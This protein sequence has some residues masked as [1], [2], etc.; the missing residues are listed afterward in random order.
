M[1]KK[2]NEEQRQ[3]GG[4]LRVLTGPHTDIEVRRR[5]QEQ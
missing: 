2:I 3:A 4:C 1:D 5:L